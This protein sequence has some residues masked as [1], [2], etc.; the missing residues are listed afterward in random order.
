MSDTN[1]NVLSSDVEIKGSITFQNELVIDG[2][3]EG[4]ITSDG[5]LTVGENAEITGEIRTR[6]CS[7]HGKVLGNITVVE[8]CE[9]QSK[10]TLIGDL[11]AAR[12]SIEEG[13]TF[14]GSSDVNPNRVEVSTPEP[15]P[16]LIEEEDNSDKIT[17]FGSL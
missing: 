9:L 16:A 1:R 11:S 7:V 13:A 4:E 5:V 17:S 3:I 10:A 6:S 12:L 8:R 2:R 15:A 14:V